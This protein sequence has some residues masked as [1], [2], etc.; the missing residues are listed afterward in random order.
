MSGINKVAPFI[1]GQY[2]YIQTQKSRAEKKTG[3]LGMMGRNQSKAFIS[4][5]LY[6][7]L[8]SQISVKGGVG[9]NPF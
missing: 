2:F 1:N 8:D 4:N 7:G 9:D 5:P 3:G 6:F